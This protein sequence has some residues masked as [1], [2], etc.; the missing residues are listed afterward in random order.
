[1][2]GENVFSFTVGGGFRGSSPH[3]RGKPILEQRQSHGQRLI[4]ACAG[5]TAGSLPPLGGLAAHP[6]MRGENSC[7]FTPAI[8]KKGSSP[9]AR[10][11]RHDSGAMSRIG[12]LIP[13]CA[14]KTAG[15][16]SCLLVWKAHPRM[17]GENRGNHYGVTSL[18]GSS[19]H[20]RGKPLT[21][22]YQA[23]S[24]RLI[25]ACA[26]KTC[27]F[28]WQHIRR[29]AHPRM[30]G[31]NHGDLIIDY[32]LDGSSPHARGKHRHH[33]HRKEWG[34]LI[35]ACAGKTFHPNAQRGWLAAH[36]RMRGENFD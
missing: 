8:S 25:P 6:R 3:A 7:S 14:G 28:I 24:S 36:P 5:K 35:P 26:G 27:F 9:H 10:G 22:G 29:K 19:P 18:V 16:M 4:P 13:A 30:R 12:G 11:K 32:N 20:A 15:K 34:R 33:H 17:R 21:C 23:T 2:R 31:E 1:M